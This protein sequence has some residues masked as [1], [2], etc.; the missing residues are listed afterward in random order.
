MKWSFQLQIWGNN[1]LF[2]QQI[3]F[4]ADGKVC[5]H[6]CTLMYRTLRKHK[7]CIAHQELTSRMMV[8]SSL[9]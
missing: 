5:A 7:K 1:S 8:T 6:H 9:H 3:N 4:G 2:S